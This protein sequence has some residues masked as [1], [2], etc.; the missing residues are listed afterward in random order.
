M[1]HECAP[2]ASA[3]IA[4]NSLKRIR[5][6]LNKP[7]ALAAMIGA[8]AVPAAQASETLDSADHETES[9][10]SIGYL[11]GHAI[12]KDS[13]V[14]NAELRAIDETNGKIIRVVVPYVNGSAEVN[15]MLPELC[16]L[17]QGALEHDLELQ[18]AFQ[19]Y[20]KS[21]PGKPGGMGY[22]P[23][24]AN[25]KWRF[26]TMVVNLLWNIAGNENPDGTKG[27]VPELEK[28]AISPYI[29]PTNSLMN[30]SQVVKGKKVAIE[31]AASLSKYIYE[32][33][34]AEAENP[35]LNIGE[36]RIFAGEIATTARHRPLATIDEFGKHLAEDAM[37][38]F[39]FHYYANGEDA[40][41]K[42]PGVKTNGATIEQITDKIRQRFGENV[43]I[44]LTELGAIAET[45]TSKE[46]QYTKKLPPNMP[47]FK[48]DGQAKF[49]NNAIKKAVCAG[50]SEVS[51]FHYTDD[52]GDVLRTG[53][54]TP[55]GEFKK[56]VKKLV[57]RPLEELKSAEEC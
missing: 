24:S 13:S 17:A 26:K 40:T 55:D 36:F 1:S 33:L 14:A 22:L 39:A 29:E 49:Y 34:H 35:D 28:L 54:R 43:L 37:D 18:I 48:G 30:K 38:G 11:S 47:I 2:P 57:V 32:P 31:R 53:L 27:C 9:S 41:S 44:V 15:N 5:E 3:D 45:P 21:Q 12:S 7:L 19:G 52:P 20:Y 50:V 23:S 6:K 8:L 4:Q 51:I 56:G 46:H 10:A 16:N 25:E 42:T